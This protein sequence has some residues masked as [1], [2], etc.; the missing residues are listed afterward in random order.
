MKTVALFFLFVTK[1][2]RVGWYG[3]IMAT[4]MCLKVCLIFIHVTL[5]WPQHW[6]FWVYSMDTPDLYLQNC[7]PV[8]T[9]PTCMI[10]MSCSCIAVFLFLKSSFQLNPSSFYLHVALGKDEAKEK[11]TLVVF[12]YPHSQGVKLKGSCTIILGEPP[13]IFCRKSL[14]GLTYFAAKSFQAS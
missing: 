9:L 6:L 3:K 5:W 7:S 11:N 1:Y 2:C 14:N 4:K 8:L 12:F 10:I 13:K